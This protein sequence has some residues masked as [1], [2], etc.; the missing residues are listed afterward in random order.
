ME[1]D[2]MGPLREEGLARGVGREDGS[3]R[4]RM[5]GGKRGLE[6]LAGKP[7]SWRGRGSSA[8]GPRIAQARR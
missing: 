1:F 3:V 5:C 6:R 4:R 2:G 7:A 8:P